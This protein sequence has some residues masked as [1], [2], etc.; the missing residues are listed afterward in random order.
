MLTTKWLEKETDHPA[1]GKH[2]IYRFPSGWGLSLI[3]G[4]IMH[5]YPYAW[6]VV[7]LDPDRR[8]NYETG[9]GDEEHVFETDEETNAFIEWAASAVGGVG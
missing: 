6:E 5:S 2:R 9:L 3:N 4:E 1:G 7:V 8:I